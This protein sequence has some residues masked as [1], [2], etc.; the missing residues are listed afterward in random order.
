[1]KYENL[2]RKEEEKYF[3]VQSISKTNKLIR[4]ESSE[5]D[6]REMIRT[7]KT[8][9]K[10]LV[11]FQGARFTSVNNPDGGSDKPTEEA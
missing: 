1:M 11:R 6:R 10:Q 7:L 3:I 9:Q 4:G 5:K 2:L 8:V